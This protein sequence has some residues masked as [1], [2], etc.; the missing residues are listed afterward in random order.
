MVCKISLALTG[1]FKV[2]FTGADQWWFNL[3]HPQQYPNHEYKQQPT[4]PN[5]LT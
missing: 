1:D 4:M 5:L 2:S 3:A